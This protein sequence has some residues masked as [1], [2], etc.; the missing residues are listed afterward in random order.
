[1][2]NDIEIIHQHR[3]GG[4][5]TALVEA[6]VDRLLKMRS[7]EI[8]KGTIGIVLPDF[9]QQRFIMREF[10]RLL[11]E[12]GIDLRKSENVYFANQVSARSLI[13]M[14]F[15]TVFLDNVDLFEDGV[16]S[17]IVEWSLRQSG[18]VVATATPD[19]ET[20]LEMLNRL[21][22][23]AEEERRH[24]RANRKLQHE[25]L[26]RDIERAWFESKIRGDI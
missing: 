2:A 17:E 23:W 3:Q 6:V 7:G 8:P 22:R 9:N 12:R 10:H 1:M 5:T 13:G 21:E 25:A 18:T 19:W 11:D 15:H 26:E 20:T 14:K 4:K 24:A 16:H